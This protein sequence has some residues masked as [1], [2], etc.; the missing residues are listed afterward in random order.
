MSYM[1]LK[2]RH[3]GLVAEARSK[4]IQSQEMEE[5]H[6]DT[7]NILTHEISQCRVSF[8]VD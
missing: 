5:R 2:K 6:R 3:D 8:A 1:E 4:E 7:V